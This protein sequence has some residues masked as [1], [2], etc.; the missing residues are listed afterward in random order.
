MNI[1]ASFYMILPALMG[2]P[3]IETTYPDPAGFG[4]NDQTPV[5]AVPGNP[6]TTLGGQRRA[7]YEAAIQIWGSRLDS[8]VVLRAR[9]I[10]D[11]LSCG[12]DTV[13]GLGGTAGLVSDFPNAPRP[14]TNYPL[15]LASALSGQRYG[16]FDTE[17]RTTYNFRVDTGDC[18]EGL[19]GFWYG[20]D[21]S[22]PPPPGTISFLE[23]SLHEIAH[24]LGFTTL[25]DRETRNFLGN[26]PLPDISAHFLFGLSQGLS[27]AQ[28]TSAQRRATSTSGPNLVWTGAQ[29]N[30]RAA[31]RLLPPGSL[32]VSPNVGGNSRFPAWVQGFPPFPPLEGLPGTLVLADGPGIGPSSDTWR[33]NLACDP[34]SNPAEMAGNVALVRRGECTFSEKIQNVYDAGAIG[35]VISDN[36]PS[37]GQAI[38]R[39]RGIAIDRN[40]PLPI[41]FVSRQTGDQL[42][43]ALPGLQ[44][45]L[46]YRLD[47]QPRGTN[48][49][50][51]NMQASTE[52][53][54]SNIAH[55][56]NQ[57]FPQSIMNP[58]LTNIG[59]TGDVDFVPDWLY[60]IGW[61]SDTGKLTQYAG[62]WFTPARDG[63]GCQL[64]QESGQ[65]LPVLTCYMYRDGEQFW[66]IGLGE[67][68]GDRYE[69]PE[70]IITEGADY[71]SAFNS[72]D[73]VRTDWGQI[74]MRLRSCNQ[75]RFEFWPRN[76]G[77]EPKTIEME[78]IV[79][80]DCNRRAVRQQN[81]AGMGNY[82][83]FERDG[84]G[85]QLVIEANNRWVL[86]YYTYLDG[87]QVWM[88][89]SA[90]RDGN[91]IDFDEMV[92]TRGGQWGQNFDPAQ[93]ERIDFG[94]IQLN[95]LD[96]NRINMRVEP[97]LE[98][99]EPSEREMHRIVPEEC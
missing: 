60:D 33:R 76:Q 95:I 69:F 87:A 19:D 71:G 90:L 66:L 59:Y 34:L 91:H 99:F 13:L 96:C 93:V 64:T 84:E 70:M 80:G 22:V 12:E 52:N 73:V 42:R 68:R 79:P 20:L 44:V 1:V 41:W 62:N 61:R 63:E 26:P 65:Q 32:D 16:N 49:G 9:A 56:S 67:H 27:W 37:G 53:T 31:E 11:D 97:I 89:G 8:N 51:V 24:G 29:A 5:Q 54:G 85:I 75:A 39:D 25:T 55:F 92:I 36:Q 30:A 77:L 40:L 94:R 4:F 82:M 18:L 21:P 74:T 50:L 88:I 7:A 28:M 15:T 86:T 2:P 38:E 72:D 57:M 47:Q 10:F 78:R 6:A 43:P 14:N 45:K 46:G 35:L 17:I 48:Q 81:R 23:L 58:S 98:Q 83:N 3:V